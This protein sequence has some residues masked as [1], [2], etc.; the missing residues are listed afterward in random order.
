MTLPSAQKKI[1]MYLPN[2]LFSSLDLQICVFNYMPVQLSVSI[3]QAILSPFLVAMQ[4]ETF[5]T[6]AKH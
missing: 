4:I 6:P 3:S 1:H 2:T 5:L